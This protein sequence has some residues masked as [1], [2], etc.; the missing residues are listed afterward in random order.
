MGNGASAQGPQTTEGPRGKSNICC[1][2]LYCVDLVAA[3]PQYNRQ[4]LPQ[5]NMKIAMM[6]WRGR[7]DGL[8]GAP[9]EMLL[10]IGISGSVN[11]MLFLFKS[12]QR[13][14]M[15]GRIFPIK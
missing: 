9:N 13:Q 12:T 10:M 6:K 3:Y 11:Q 1:W 14:Y 7:E 4:K 5:I 8:V 2:I 15:A